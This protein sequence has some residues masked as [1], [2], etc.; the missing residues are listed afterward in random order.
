MLY[1][2]ARSRL[3]ARIR[4]EGLHEGLSGTYVRGIDVN[5]DRRIASDLAAY[6]A[7]R[8]GGPA[9][10]I[11]LRFDGRA[12]LNTPCRHCGG[13]CPVVP[14]IS[15]DHVV[16][17]ERVASDLGARFRAPQFVAAYRDSRSRPRSYE[18]AV[19]LW[20]RLNARWEAAN[21]VA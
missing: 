7:Y 15:A 12:D 20:E 21:G 1:H 6:L 8:D 2:A 17:I 9:L 14:P 5:P 3:E 11:Q 4:R 16:A 19:A 13:Y 10:L 18:A